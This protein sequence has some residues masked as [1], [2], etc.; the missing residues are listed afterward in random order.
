MPRL[1]LPS[2]GIVLAPLATGHSP[3]QYPPKIT[4]VLRQ[5]S[6]HPSARVAAVPASKRVGATANP[7][8][9]ALIS[10]TWGN[11]DKEDVD[12]LSALL[13]E[14]RDGQRQQLERQEEALSI[15]RAHFEI[16]K[17]QYDRANSINDQAE[18]IQAK[19]AALIDRSGR[20][21]KIVIPILVILIV[22][23]GSMAFCI[24]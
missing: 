14:I 2:V 21:F 18:R 23:V 7:P 15:Q 16:A 19:S 10:L 6:Q 3:P 5:G 13:Q 20:V 11:M 17:T 8:D 9:S 22:V 1:R 4:Q 24:R 12:R